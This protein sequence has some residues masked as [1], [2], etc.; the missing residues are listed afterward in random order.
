[1]TFSDAG[2]V[3]TISYTIRESLSALVNKNDQ[4][5]QKCIL[6]FYD[7]CWSSYFFLKLKTIHYSLSVN[8]SIIFDLICFYIND[9]NC[10]LLSQSSLYHSVLRCFADRGN[11]NWL[12]KYVKPQVDES[13]N[14]E[15]SCVSL[16]SEK[17]ST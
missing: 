5:M 2:E 7:K 1:M 6:H 8:A 14:A 9:E 15:V 3:S 10:I 16:I 4:S 12:I 17:N 13:Q 11:D